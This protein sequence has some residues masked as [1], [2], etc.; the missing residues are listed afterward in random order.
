[1]LIA[2]PA[3]ASP[4]W[5]S[6]AGCGHWPGRRGRKSWPSAARMA[7]S[8]AGTWPAGRRPCWAFSPARPRDPPLPQDFCGTSSPGAEVPLYA[9]EDTAMQPPTCRHCGDTLPEDSPTGL[10]SC[11]AYCDWRARDEGDMLGEETAAALVLYRFFCEWDCALG[12][13]QEII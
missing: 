5:R 9:P 3:G 2:R 11:R 13:G 6:A 12:K 1:R 7:A 8:A 10:T 4:P